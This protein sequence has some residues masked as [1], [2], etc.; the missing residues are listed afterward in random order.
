[1]GFPRFTKYLCNASISLASPCVRATR[2]GDGALGDWDTW[3]H[4]LPPPPPPGGHPSH[5]RDDV[6]FVI[7]N[8]ILA[9]AAS[10]LSLRGNGKLADS[11]F[12]RVIMGK[13]LN[14]RKGKG[15]QPPIWGIT[16]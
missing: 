13:M 9:T 3:T 11:N 2:F 16:I 14:T 5:L 1:V 10:D 8:Q 15:R 4:P 7:V 12:G 6:G